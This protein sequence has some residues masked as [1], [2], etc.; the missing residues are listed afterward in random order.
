MIDSII[1][2]DPQTPQNTSRRATVMQVLPAMVTGGV[3]R[4]TV[5]MA[6]AIVNAGGRAIV[7]SAGGPMVHDL[8]RVGAEHIQMPVDSKN[9]FVM[10]KN[11]TRLVNLMKQ[12]GVDLVHARSR[13]PAWSAY[14][15]CKRAHVP[16]ITTF[17]GT[18]SHGNPL[19]RW[20]NSVMTKGERVIAISS[21]IAGHMRKIYGVR[22]ET[23][24]LIHRGVDLF[25]FNPEKITA[26][27]LVKLS[28]QWNIPDGVPVVALPG[29]LTRWK[30]QLVFIDA[31]A[32]LDRRDICCLLIGSDQG[33]TEYRKELEKRIQHHNLQGVVTIVDECND[34]PT[35]Y[36]LCDLVVS[37]STDPEAFGRVAIEAQAMGR[38]VVATDHGGA[39]ETVIEDQTGWL[40]K[41]GDAD[42]MA[43][44]IEKGLNLSVQ[45]REQMAEQAKAHIAKEFSK[46][47]MCAKTLE[48]YNEVLSLDA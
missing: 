34:M 41:P 46:E 22:R 2:Q 1:Q 31:I 39:R 23:I 8:T 17:H 9:F 21:F 27:R 40:C 3:E 35:A 20:Y 36:M 26:E 7:V 13:A 43:S 47:A 11:A 42:S 28:T 12:E 29:R 10:R 32:K 45:K 4:G 38:P 14:W 37:A 6:E 44:A 19:K 24:R 16:Y 15:A 33:R 30:G 48:V 5:E 18:Y 25:R